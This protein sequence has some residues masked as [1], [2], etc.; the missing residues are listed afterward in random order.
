[1]KRLTILLFLVFSFKLTVYSEHYSYSY[2]KNYDYSG[3]YEKVNNYNPLLSATKQEVVKKL[4][5]FGKNDHEKLYSI[6]IFLTLKIDYDYTY[7][8]Y[9]SDE[10]FKYRSG[11]CNGFSLLFVDLCRIAG[12]EAEKLSGLAK[13]AG[14]EI[15]KYFYDTKEEYK[16]SNHAWNKVKLYGKWYLIEATWASCI[17]TD[18]AIKEY[19]LAD[20][21]LF[22][23]SHLPLKSHYDPDNEEWFYVGDFADQLLKR[24]VTYREFVTT[25]E[26]TGEKYLAAFI[27][28]NNDDLIVTENKQALSG[29]DFDLMNSFEELLGDEKIKML[30]GKTSQLFMEF[31]DYFSSGEMQGDVDEFIDSVE[32]YW[33]SIEVR[34][35]RESGKE[36]VK[37]GVELII[38][39]L[40]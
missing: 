3:V 37:S 14:Y 11:V 28:D 8:R 39:I 1:M 27:E 15:K 22:V 34:D 23:Y 7:I 31:K 9:Y 2:L 38:S 6:Y 17:R 21:D 29:S 35:F 16:K 24:P 12:F 26:D 32:K 5:S 25:D 40:K 33:N 10:T 18:R 4:I 30:Q 13:A 19:W 36:F 20:P